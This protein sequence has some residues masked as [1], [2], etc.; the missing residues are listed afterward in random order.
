MEIYVDE[1]DR[2][3]IAILQSN[4]RASNA[5]IARGIGVS[6]GTVRRR[7]KKLIADGVI[8]II[9]VVD[10]ER[11]GYD[12]EALVGVQVDPD[13]VMDVAARLGELPESNW[14]AITTGTYDVFMWV[15]LQSADQ[16]GTF[17]REKL[18]VVSG[19]RRTETFVRLSLPKK[20][21]SVDL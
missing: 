11:L 12:T 1:L 3:I 8:E 2:E 4:G 20:S 7:L 16:L 17:L 14:V 15:T 10:A 21:T 18:G 6:E 5:R 9:A 19:V 13:K